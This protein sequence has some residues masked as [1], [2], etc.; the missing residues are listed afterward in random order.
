[1]LGEMVLKGERA[2]ELVQ[3]LNRV[4]QK[5]IDLVKENWPAIQCV[6]E[7]LLTHHVLTEDEIDALIAQPKIKERDDNQTQ[8]VK[9]E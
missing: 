9:N 4:Q 1:M 3:L 7:A 2:E 8:G 5:S 6:A